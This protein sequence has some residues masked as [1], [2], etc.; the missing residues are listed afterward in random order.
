MQPEIQVRLLSEFS[1]VLGDG[2]VTT[3]N[4]PRL[5]ALLAYLLLHRDAPQSRQHI[6][7]LFW[8]DS[9]EEQ[10]L[11]NLR[12]LI[13]AL[14]RALPDLERYISIDR[15][16]LQWRNDNP[17]SLDVMEFERSLAEARRALHVA[18]N[19]AEHA[20]GPANTRPARASALLQ[21]T[22]DLYT[23]DLL[24][25]CYDEWV[26][27][28][29]EHLRQGFLWSLTALVS[30]LESV[31]EFNTAAL[32]AQR[33]LRHDP[34]QEENYRR[35]MRVHL[36]NGDR[37]GVI[38]VYRH[39]ERI[40]RRELGVEPS[41]A[42]RHLLQQAEEL[43]G[44]GDRDERGVR[45]ASRRKGRGKSKAPGRAPGNLPAQT[46]EFIGREREVVAVSNL[47]RQ[48]GR[49]LVTLTGTPGTGKTRLAIQVASGLGEFADGV[50]FVSLAPLTEPEMVERSI[51]QALG[52]A[53]SASLPLRD[54]LL[55]A[56]RDRHILLV[57]DNFEHL[58]PAAGVVAELLAPCPHLKVLA[59][60]RSPLNLRGEHEYAVPPL[61]VP[62]RDAPPEPDDL[63]Q[64]EAVSLFVERAIE[65][66]PQFELTRRNA[67]AVAEICRRLEGLPLAVEL[68]AARVKVL[69]PEA[70]LSRLGQRFKLL[71][72]GKV[73]L[74]PRQRALEAAITW[75]YNLLDE[76]EKKLFRELSVFAGGCSLDAVEKV[77]G[78]QG[79]ELDTRTALD[80][81]T[82]L[83][84]KSLVTRVEVE[85]GSIEAL[86]EPRFGMLETLREYGLHRL[87]EAGEAHE[88]A[89]RH[90]VY[91]AELVEALAARYFTP[92]QAAMLR[93]V[94]R[95]HDNIRAAL[96]W[97]CERGEAEI[98]MRLAGSLDRFWERRG[99]F[100][101]GRAWLER[102]LALQPGR[103]TQEQPEGNSRLARAR[104]NALRGLGRFQFRMGEYSLAE[105]TLS[106][107]AALFETVGDKEGI[108]DA[109]NVMAAAVGMNEFDRGLAIHERCLTIRREIDDRPGIIA[110][111]QSIAT[112]KVSK[113]EHFEARLLSLEA[114]ALHGG[115]GGNDTK[116]AI[117]YALGAATAGLRDY[118]EAR[119]ILT[120]CSTVCRE[121]GNQR[122]LAWA[123][124]ELAGIA[125]LEDDDEQSRRLNAEALD[126]FVQQGA[127]PGIAHTY[128]RMG[129]DE[130]R[131]GHY[132]EAGGLYSQAF[133]QA[134]EIGLI[135][136]IGQALGG[137]AGV[138][139]ALGGAHDAAVL[140]GGAEAILQGI[141][142]SLERED[143]TFNMAEA[144]T[145][146]GEVAWK[147]SWDEGYGLTWEQVVD[148]A[149]G[150]L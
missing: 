93:L 84:N 141:H 28:P 82:S 120:E 57:L 50:Y 74:P 77:L 107:S 99:H 63:I 58:L 24:P 23:G 15:R 119:R 97:S 46:A 66:F 44:N 95:E 103:V 142:S 129:R 115:D 105:A 70:I 125:F 101:E 22:V 5:Q 55:E 33:L 78:A 109:L 144:R 133:A 116:A 118:D 85:A 36:A 102:A 130:H 47:L 92:S 76:E 127:R 64:Y 123:L 146:L 110:S 12:N 6:A 56:L 132:V 71:V 18:G 14:R 73:D 51:A 43:A 104:A 21:E 53:E 25:A 72:G 41:D 83:L 91:F 1:V 140:F 67:P 35:L 52:V 143:M 80:G 148:R 134:V 31:G 98:A 30:G 29:R 59:T 88:A 108:A 4:T 10:A 42:T 38:S 135:P 69:A 48:P 113:G 20:H 2:P 149:R 87:T 39:C 138:V 3:L 8:P 27:A 139:A 37:A 75:S 106:E 86:E 16:S 26:L 122:L 126:I 79:R 128:A 147:A 100:G 117:L 68:A 124:Y 150:L 11:S 114:L 111:L 62:G 9:S 49:R 131:L 19:G 89:R 61:T 90:A 121:I 7:F 54:S 137:A 94:E 17:L 13:M 45:S 32:Y 136:A 96:H 34:L 40:M 81:M 65:V 112:I 60:S 145:L